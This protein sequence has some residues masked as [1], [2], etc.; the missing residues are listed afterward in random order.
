MNP[1]LE[2][3]KLSN[4]FRTEAARLPTETRSRTLLVLEEQNLR[5]RFLGLEELR[6]EGGLPESWHPYLDKFYG[7]VF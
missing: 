2:A 1:Q 7:V 6:K 4:W 3:D 5:L